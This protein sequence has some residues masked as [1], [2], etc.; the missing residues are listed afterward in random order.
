M[1]RSIYSITSRTALGNML[2]G[3][4]LVG[5]SAS[6][7]LNPQGW[8]TLCAAA[9][10]FTLGSLS[11]F[12]CLSPRREKPDE[13]SMAHDG[14]AAR[15]A[16]HIVLIA[17]GIVSAAS[18]ALGLEVDAATLGLGIIGLGLLVYGAAFAW[19]ER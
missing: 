8:V 9:C 14:L 12:A 13:M 16:F 6:R 5:L 10:L 17:V 3:F 11:L 15:H 19:L 18:M 2:I 7:A 1:D 4:A